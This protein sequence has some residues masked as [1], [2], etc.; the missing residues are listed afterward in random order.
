MKNCLIYKEMKNITNWIEIFT[1][2]WMMNN[3]MKNNKHS[4]EKMKTQWNKWK[5]KNWYI[6]YTEIKKLSL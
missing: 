4:K 3:K 1:E 6:N 2:T 5:L